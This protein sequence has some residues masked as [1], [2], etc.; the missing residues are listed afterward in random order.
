MYTEQKNPPYIMQLDCE[1]DGGSKLMQLGRFGFHFTDSNGT[2]FPEKVR[3]LE[4]NNK[5]RSKH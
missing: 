3:N 1:T 4:R 5:M 2:C